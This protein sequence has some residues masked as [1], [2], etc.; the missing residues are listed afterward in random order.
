MHMCSLFNLSFKKSSKTNL[1][2]TIINQDQTPNS[3]KVDKELTLGSSSRGLGIRVQIL[4]GGSAFPFAFTS[5]SKGGC[6][7]H[8][9][10]A[11]SVNRM[12]VIDGNS[13]DDRQ[14]EDKVQR[15]E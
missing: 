5:E 13:E 3:L 9:M 14:T 6:C 10:L 1:L 11:N 2:K 8:N 12:L 4:V 15:G 7:G